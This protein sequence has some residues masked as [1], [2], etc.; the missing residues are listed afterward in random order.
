MQKDFLQTQNK[1]KNL[2]SLLSR[3]LFFQ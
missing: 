3:L 1:I 2:T